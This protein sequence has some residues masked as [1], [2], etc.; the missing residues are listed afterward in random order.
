MYKKTFI[1]KK[2]LNCFHNLLFSEQY[3]TSNKW[4]EK[5]QKLVGDELEENYLEDGFKLHL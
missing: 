3:K 1:R 4:T 5:K 2:W